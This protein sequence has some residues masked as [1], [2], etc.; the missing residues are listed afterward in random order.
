MKSKTIL[1]SAL[2]ATTFL[3][4]SA[5]SYADSAVVVTEQTDSTS[6]TSTNPVRAIANGVSNV[7]NSGVNAVKD[8]AEAVTD[9]VDTTNKS[10]NVV[11]ETTTPAAVV[12]KHHHQRGY[13]NGY[14]GYRHH[15]PH[16]YR[17]TDGWYYP[18]AAF[19]DT[20][21]VV[22]KKEVDT[23]AVN[24]LPAK[25]L[26]YCQSHYRSYRVSDNS[27]Q[28]YSGPRQQCYSKYY[29]GNR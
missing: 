19:K 20:T 15:R 24:N 16:Y 8:G 22:E 21:G 9:A 23:V 11:V 14:K 27:F 17:Y 1:K 29:R 7:V 26:R 5:Y 28:P 12:V 25:H 4:A 18:D 6:T 2:M 3:C 10:D 13:L